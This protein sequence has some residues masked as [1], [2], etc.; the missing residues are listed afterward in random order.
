MRGLFIMALASKSSL[1]PATNPERVDY[2]CNQ[3]LRELMISQ[4]IVKNPALLHHVYCIALLSDYHYSQLQSNPENPP[5]SLP[6]I[7]KL[8][9]ILMDPAII[10]AQKSTP[11]HELIAGEVIK[12]ELTADRNFGSILKFIKMPF[13]CETS[14]P[15]ASPCTARTARPTE[16]ASSESLCI[17]KLSESKKHCNPIIL[18]SHNIA[19]LYATGSLIPRDD[20]LAA[21]YYEMAGESSRFEE[22]T[23]GEE[24]AKTE[25]KT[26]AQPRDEVKHSPSSGAA[27]ASH[28]LSEQKHFLWQKRKGCYIEKFYSNAFDHCDPSL[29]TGAYHDIFRDIHHAKKTI[30]LAGWTMM[31]SKK[32]IPGGRTLAD[33]LY[34]AANRGVNVILLVWNN[35]MG[36]YKTSQA[37]DQRYMRSS[38]LTPDLTFSDDFL[39]KIH[40]KYVD[41]AFGW[42]AHQKFQIIDDKVFLG[43]L[44]MMEF[45]GSHD[46]HVALKGSIVADCLELIM[47]RWQAARDTLVVCSPTKNRG[48]R[49]FQAFCMLGEAR[50]QLT[51]RLQ[52]ETKESE[53]S[54]EMQLVCSIQRKQLALPDSRWKTA[55]PFTTELQDNLIALI[56]SADRY[57]IMENQYFMGPRFKNGADVPTT[58]QVVN[59][60][61]NKILEKHRAGKPFHIY[62]LLPY[63]PKGG[64]EL[65]RRAMLRNQYKSIAWIYHKIGQVVGEGQGYRY[66]TFFQLGQFDLP[67]DCVNIDPL[68]NKF[69]QQYVHSKIYIVDSK[70]LMIGSANC[71][72]RSLSGD[73]DIENMVLIDGPSS[74]IHSF[75]FSLFS[76]HF[77]T[78]LMNRLRSLGLDHQLEQPGCVDLIR[79]HLNGRLYSHTPLRDHLDRI[80]LGNAFPWGN[81][82]LKKLAAGERP[83]HVEAKKP[84]RVRLV[85]GISEFAT[86]MSH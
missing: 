74:T 17:T 81:I 4:G 28:I 82:D 22:K 2:I 31:L 46:V 78:R 20:V 85:A 33:H 71:S 42:S 35:Q 77:G 1:G 68:K 12:S 57:I 26:E 37:D 52:K 50:Q 13:T 36:A 14:L 86:R 3:L 76:E 53:V 80:E 48:L 45:T 11:V 8:I 60:L 72:E 56:Q 58:N 65:G 84:L 55:T 18:L 30:V 21:R 47:G 54:C 59:A 79:R 27:R 19:V 39:N 44:D 40:I 75:V 24:E 5:A 43:G 49:D 73:G 67:E 38:P 83:P 9:D 69:M 62:C 32:L 10:L 63:E 7:K 70:C 29:G 23:E 6:I 16:S 34:S 61:L 15:A 66:L 64:G 41:T 25:A 51:E